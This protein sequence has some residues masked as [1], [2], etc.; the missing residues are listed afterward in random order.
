M[1]RQPASATLFPYPTHFRSG[2]LGGRVRPGQTG[3][4]EEAG[5][6]RQVPAERL[7]DGRVP[8]AGEP[9]E[10]VRLGERVHV[11]VGRSEEHTSE[12]QSRHYF[13]CRPLLLI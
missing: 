3:A 10:E 9:V 11:W 13:V 8:G 6:L 12:L 5:D 1:I 2:P 4:A 7:A